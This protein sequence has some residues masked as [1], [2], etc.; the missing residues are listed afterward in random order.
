MKILELSTM[1]CAK[2]RSELED[3]YVVHK[4]YKLLY[5]S[6][7]LDGEISAPRGGGPAA[8]FGKAPATVPWQREKPVA[9]SPEPPLSGKRTVKKCEE[10][11]PLYPLCIRHIVHIC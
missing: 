3:A 8:A 5:K 6:I 4:F 10:D 9:R 1:R 7:H 2:I 11:R